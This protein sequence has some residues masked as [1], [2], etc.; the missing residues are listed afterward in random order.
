M[1]ESHS[2]DGADIP[3]VRFHDPDDESISQYVAGSLSELELAEFEKHLLLCDR[4]RS[5]VTFARALRTELSQ[6]VKGRRTFFIAATLAVAASL[7]VAVTRS[8]DSSVKS[9]GH[10]ATAPVYGGLPVRASDSTGHSAFNAAMSSYQR[11]LYADAERAFRKARAANADS[12]TT[13]FFLGASLLM[14]GKP[15]EAADEF[16]RVGGMSFSSYTSESHFYR[17]KALLQ[18]GKTREAIAA[19]EKASA[20]AGPIQSHAKSLTDSIEAAR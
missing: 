17:A 19:L 1:I 8:G 20:V 2:P 13:S 5:E 11:G 18:L 9:L 3:V 7:A 14:S 6:S 12:V 4:C 15:R 16:G 10:V